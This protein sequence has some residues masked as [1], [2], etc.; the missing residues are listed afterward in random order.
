MTQ[1]RKLALETLYALYAAGAEGAECTIVSKSTDEINSLG[2]AV[3]LLREFDH[4]DIDLSAVKGGNKA[5]MR[6]NQ[7]DHE[8]IRNAAAHCVAMA[9][10]GY[11]AEKTELGYKGQIQADKLLNMQRDPDKLYQRFKELMD[12]LRDEY[13]MISSDA[14]AWYIDS[15]TLYLNTEGH[16]V[17]YQTQ[18][19]G[20]GW[21]GGAT[22]GVSTTDCEFFQ[23]DCETLET[24]FIDQGMVRDK[25][26][27]VQRML[28][29]QKIEG[30]KFIGTIIVNPESV[31]RYVNQ[32]MERVKDMKENDGFP[33]PD[34]SACVSIFRADSDVAYES[35]MPAHNSPGAVVEYVIRNGEV[36][37]DPTKDMSS[38]EKA[39]HEAKRQRTLKRLDQQIIGVEAGSIPY[40]QLISNVKRGLL[41]GHVQGTMPS[42]DGEF[43]GAAKNS[44]YIEDGEIKHPVVETMLSGNVFEMFK[45]VEGISSETIKFYDYLMPWMAFGGITIL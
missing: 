6:I 19:C 7:T 21:Q 44:F 22:D 20:C 36:V 4:T 27:N 30:D 8:S 42:P 3:Y 13:P 17:S 31:G 9:G 16:E 29:P 24:P 12:T 18:Y 40:K 28:N 34:C 15:K 37:P 14:M 32:V 41:I 1:L 10:Y 25:L 39:A 2:K 5:S 11:P 38:S 35:G 23:I 26:E 33:S 43:S 45:H